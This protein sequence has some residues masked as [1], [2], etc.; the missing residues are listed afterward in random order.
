MAARYHAGELAV[1]ARAGVLDMAERVGRSVRRTIPSAAQDFLREQP[2]AVAATVDAAGDVWASLLTGAPGFVSVLDEETVRISTL[3]RSGDPFA[4]NLASR[5]EIGLV[6]VEFATRRRMRL[7]GRAERTS[8]GVVVRVEQVFSNCPKYI[9]ARDWSLAASTGSTA[10]TCSALSV[11]QQRLVEGADTFFIATFHPESGADASHRGGQPGFVRATD[12]RR[13]AWPD[14]QGNNMFLT[15]G[16]VAEY[17]RAGLLFVDFERG[18]TLQLSGRATITWDDDRLTAFP[19]A[20]RLVEF[21]V[22]RVVEI[23][24]GIGVTWRFRGYSPFNPV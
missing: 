20:E 1:Q 18:L 19:G 10:R 12:D 8:D 22:E 3:G 14:Y 21:E 6:S 9:Q 7:N 4:E 16:N 13:L 11:E 24:G 23:A 15:L 2:M 5:S 17:P